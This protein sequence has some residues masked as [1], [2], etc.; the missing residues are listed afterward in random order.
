MRALIL[1]LSTTLVLAAC[2]GSA[3]G[4]RI[5]FDGEIFRG[6]A[7]PVDRADRRDFIAT[8]GPVSRSEV[9]VREAVRYEG[10]QY[11]IR[12]FGVSDIDW[13]VDP[14]AETLPRNGNKVVLQGRCVE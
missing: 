11:C 14:Q 10:T 1:L 2:D 7:K 8:A 6:S 13:Q 9:G 3:D 4:K 5:T 12:W